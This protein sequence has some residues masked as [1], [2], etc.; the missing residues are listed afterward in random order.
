MNYAGH[1]RYEPDRVQAAY[2]TVYQLKSHS[3]TFAEERRRTAM[4]Y[5]AVLFVCF[6]TLGALALVS[7]V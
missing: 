7:I 5:I 6:L 1:E 3:S 4:V 2:E